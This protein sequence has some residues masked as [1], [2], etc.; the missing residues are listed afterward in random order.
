MPIDINKINWG[1]RP[2][3]SDAEA[4]IGCRMIFQSGRLEF[5]PGRGSELG[6]KSQVQSLVNWFNTTALPALKKH[7]KKQG[8]NS[9]T[10]ETFVFEDG[11]KR[12][13]A[14]PNGSFGYMYISAYIMPVIEQQMSV[15][16]VS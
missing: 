1:K 7:I 15:Q 11:Q 3:R 2:F 6:E 9:A 14:S 10:T 4:Y 16:Q 13:E 12:L 8:W 5:L